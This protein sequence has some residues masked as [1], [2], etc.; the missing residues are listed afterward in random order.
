MQANGTQHPRVPGHQEARLVN[1]D[2]LETEACVDEVVGREA[3]QHQVGG[4]PG[5]ELLQQ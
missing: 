2:G 5:A 1:G 3:H 4:E